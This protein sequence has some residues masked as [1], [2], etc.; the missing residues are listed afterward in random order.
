M[1]NLL[2]FSLLAFVGVY[3]YFNILFPTPEE[4]VLVNT[5]P[6]VLASTDDMLAHAF[7]SEVKFTRDVDLS[8]L[9]DLEKINHLFDNQLSNV[10]VRG[11]GRVIKMLPDDNDGSRHQRFIVR[12][13]NN[14]TVLV[15]HN[16]DIG[17]R[18]NSLRAGDDIG[19]SGV[20]EWNDK[21][22]VVHWTHKD[23]NGKHPDGYLNYVGLTYN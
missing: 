1:K 14:Q 3:V 20:Y 19:F 6:A 4:T 18:V 8:K 7:D 10:Q 22:G 12:L 2:I 11:F 5:K 13:K 9:S 17:S 21:G 16:I 23:P 15:A